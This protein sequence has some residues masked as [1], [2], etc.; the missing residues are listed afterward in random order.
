VVLFLIFGGFV[1]GGGGGVKSRQSKYL[2]SSSSS[3]SFSPNIRS[4]MPTSAQVI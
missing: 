3:F 1:W 4:V 2:F